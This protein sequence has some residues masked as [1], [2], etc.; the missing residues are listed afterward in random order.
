MY[1]LTFREDAEIDR[2]APAVLWRMESALDEA[3]A[4]HGP[5]LRIAVLEAAG[6]GEL[7]GQGRQQQSAVVLGG[8]LYRLLALVF[9]HLDV[10]RHLYFG[11]G[12]GR[13]L[14]PR[15]QL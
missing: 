2:L 11:D 4:P 7:G 14:F 1:I 5:G 13:A 6:A 8:Q 10:A 15:V 12:G 3:H 9:R